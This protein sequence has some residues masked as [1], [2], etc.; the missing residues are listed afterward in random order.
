MKA[1][2]LRV[3]QLGAALCG[4]ALLAGSAPAIARDDL[5][6]A[7][8][9]GALIE[10]YPSVTRWEITR[11]RGAGA[12]DAAVPVQRVL[13]VGSRSA[14]RSSDG[15]TTWYVV[16]G[17]VPGWVASRELPSHAPTDSRDWSPSPV[18]LLSARC[19]PLT[20]FPVGSSWRTRRETVQGS[21]LNQ[22][23]LEAMP[24]IRRGE[25]VSLRSQVR[26]VSVSSQGLALTDAALGGGIAVR[27]LGSG[28]VVHGRVAQSSEVQVD[29]LH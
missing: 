12:G 5:A 22:C 19:A 27:A 15:T 2:A 18:D 14:V 3:D 9:R 4:A 8:L 6:P 24:A 20:S 26:G 16:R 7:V 11:L 23:S 17:W 28:R 10:T 1:L 21:L 13:R 25:T 29:V